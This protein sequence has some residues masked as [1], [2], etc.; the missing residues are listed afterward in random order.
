MAIASGIAEGFV[1]DMNPRTM[2]RSRGAQ[3]SPLLEGAKGAPMALIAADEAAYAERKAIEAEHDSPLSRLP[4][5]ERVRREKL[6]RM[7]AAGLDPF[8]ASFHPDTEIEAIRAE[9]GDLAPMPGPAASSASRAASC[10]T[11]CRAR[12]SSPRSTTSPARSR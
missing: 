12:S 5:Q 11:A 8:V 4:E 1:P 10:A 9:F 2:L 3:G 7:V 6:E